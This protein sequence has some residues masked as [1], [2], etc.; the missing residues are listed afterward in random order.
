MELFQNISIN[1][2][3][4]FW[5]VRKLGFKSFEGRPSEV[6]ADPTEQLSVALVRH[7][8]VAHMLHTCYTHVTHMTHVC[9]YR[10][11]SVSPRKLDDWI[12][13]LTQP[14]LELP[15]N[16]HGL[17]W[18]NNDGMAL[19][20]QNKMIYPHPWRIQHA[21]GEWLEAG[22]SFGQDLSRFE[23]FLT[24]FTSEQLLAMLRHLNLRLEK[25]GK[26]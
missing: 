14:V 18:E 3:R 16:G 6:V 22:C 9:V 12:F 15:I 26:T 24:M 10:N 23:Y 5:F 7:S 11:T 20:H 19:S 21:S 8:H 17:V 13:H 25:A 2:I 4:A 1:E